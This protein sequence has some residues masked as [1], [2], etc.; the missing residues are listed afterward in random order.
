MNPAATLDMLRSLRLS[1]MAD[2]YEA[3]L[4]GGDSTITA[5]ELVARMAE[6]EW[7]LRHQ[8]KTERLLKHARLRLPASL[9]GIVYSPERA[10]DRN[11]VQV[12][13]DMQWVT[14]GETVLVTG[15]TG[16]GKSYLACAFGHEACLRGTTTRY[17]RATKLFPTLRMARGDG[18]YLEEIRRIAR[19][20]LLIIDDF[21]LTPLDADDRL[22]LLE[23]LDDRYRTA[24]TIIAAQIPIEA[25]HDII[26]EPTIADAI[27]DR[28]AHTH[29]IF[30]LKG[31][32]RRATTASV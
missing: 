23:I 29:W 18:T 12:L 22:A 5:S 6:T 16:A 10:I 24:G 4:R 25:W 17:V 20:Q 19:T 21:G 8:R 26:G 14:R 11:T 32:S 3:T 31:G 28:L 27:M 9:D 30:Q 7:N 15:P 1:G 2:A 13:G